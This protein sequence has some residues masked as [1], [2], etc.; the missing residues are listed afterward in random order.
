MRVKGVET[1]ARRLGSESTR[2]VNER[3]WGEGRSIWK[4]GEVVPWWGSGRVSKLEQKKG[5]WG[6]E[7]QGRSKGE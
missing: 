3:R 2:Y 7:K 6:G 4:V 5:R 1:K